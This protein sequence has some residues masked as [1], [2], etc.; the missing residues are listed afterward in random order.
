MWGEPIRV[1]SSL[2]SAG[3]RIFERRQRHLKH[4]EVL[5][6]GRVGHVRSLP[7]REREIV[8]VVRDDRQPRVTGESPEQPAIE[9]SL[10]P[11]LKPRNDAVDLHER[12][13]LAA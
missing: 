10:G 3:S 13:Y 9:L 8:R 4:R 7:V 2:R 6:R 5:H 11:T 12:A 1:S